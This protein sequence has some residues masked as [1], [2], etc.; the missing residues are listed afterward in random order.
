[1]KTIS[2]LLLLSLLGGCGDHFTD[3]PLNSDQR[4]QIALS[5]DRQ[6][7][8]YLAGWID[9]HCG[10]PPTPDKPNPTVGKPQEPAKEPTK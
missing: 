9:G 6:R 5:L 3:Q 4:V 7:A 1:M 10:R 2:A 8:A